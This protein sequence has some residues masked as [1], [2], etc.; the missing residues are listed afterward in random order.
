[1]ITT[2]KSALLL[3]GVL[4]LTA[5]KKEGSAT[6][7]DALYPTAVGANAAEST[8]PV[9]MIAQGKAL[10]EG[11]GTCNSCHLADKKVIGPS[12]KEITKIYDEHQAS[13]VT[14]LQGEGE[15]IVDPSQFPIMQAN[16]SITKK[17]SEHE[18]RAIEA[19]MRSF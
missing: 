1:M 19:Y 16:F 12:I 8:D 6:E 13:I 15:A 2:M 5:C 9:K 4:A 11:K 18:L 17:M 3:L 7:K 14:F 10:F